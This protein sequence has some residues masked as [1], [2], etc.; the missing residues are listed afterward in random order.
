MLRSR[1]APRAFLVRSTPHVQPSVVHPAAMADPLDRKSSQ[2]LVRVTYTGAWR[3]ILL[4]DTGVPT[5]VRG[6]VFIPALARRSAPHAV[7]RGERRPTEH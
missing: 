1:F 4:N 5:A 3:R 6:R 7:I 2:R